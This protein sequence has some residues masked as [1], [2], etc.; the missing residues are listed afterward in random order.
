[1]DIKEE[2]EIK[3]EFQLERVVLFTDAVFAIILTIMV[4]ELKLPEGIR[5]KP[6]E[7]IIESFKELIFK[8]FGYCISFGL[9]GRFWVTHLRLFRNLKDYDRTL[10]ILNLL[11]LFTVTLFPF[12]VSLVSGSLA[13]SSHYYAWGFT[14]YILIFFGVVFV[15]ALISRHLI[16]NKEKLCMQAS[17]LESNVK[18]KVQKV[19][20]IIVP[21]LAII[22]LAFNYFQ[23]PYY[24]QLV[25]I[26][27]FGFTI[28][29]LTKK[30]Y[31]NENNSP[32]IARLFKS[33]KV[34]KSLK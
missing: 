30:Y 26:G 22:V 4:L 19:V 12:A 34:A 10:L 33:K 7:E 9:V 31:P 5:H 8:F 27:C 1:M 20:L 28:G 21:I 17:D 15:Q 2:E 29:K 32:M 24:Y 16:L 23:L 13:P 25:T 18:W 11:F 14:I 6:E 3:K